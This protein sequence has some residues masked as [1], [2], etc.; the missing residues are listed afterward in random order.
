M[1]SRSAKRNVQN[2]AVKGLS[3]LTTARAVMRA[4]SLCSRLH[5]RA[6]CAASF[7]SRPKTMMFSTATDAQVEV[8]RRLAA[9]S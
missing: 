3:V 8:I 1:P 5:V 2:V 9:A 6:R 7:R 4:D